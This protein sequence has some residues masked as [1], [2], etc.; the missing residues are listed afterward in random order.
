[1]MSAMR[2][3][4]KMAPLRAVPVAAEKF[5]DQGLHKRLGVENAT[6]IKKRLAFFL[7]F[8]RQKPSHDAKQEE[9]KCQK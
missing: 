2:Q 3:K 1:M 5:I 9:N 7:Y 6:N 4:S 8:V